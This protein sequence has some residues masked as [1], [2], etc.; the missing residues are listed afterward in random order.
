MLWNIWVPVYCRNLAWHDRRDDTNASPMTTDISRSSS[1]ET[2]QINRHIRCS[3]KNNFGVIVFHYLNNQYPYSHF[4]PYGCWDVTNYCW[5]S[6]LATLCCLEACSQFAQSTL[7]SAV[8]LAR[9][10]AG[11]LA[12]SLVRAKSGQIPSKLSLSKDIE[13]GPWPQWCNTTSEPRLSCLQ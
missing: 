6:T 9:Q 11:E 10:K 5:A 8:C 12:V 3:T 2:S 4:I 1:M 7:T 13:N